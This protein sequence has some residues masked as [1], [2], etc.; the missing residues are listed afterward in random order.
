MSG[1]TPA[2]D[3]G[4]PNVVNATTG[5]TVKARTTKKARHKDDQARI[6]AHA[7]SVGRT[8]KTPERGGYEELEEQ[9]AAT[10]EQVPVVPKRDNAEPEPG[11]EHVR[12]DIGSHVVVFELGAQDNPEDLSGPFRDPQGAEMRWAARCIT[13]G[14]TRYFARHRAAI[15]AV[16]ASHIWCEGCAEAVASNRR[17]RHRARIRMKEATE[18]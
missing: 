15:Q 18:S 8:G 9:L 10:R 11:R 3:G 7:R 1:F 5:F 6:T 13:H 4:G 14:E 2:R 17:I 12:R 16:R